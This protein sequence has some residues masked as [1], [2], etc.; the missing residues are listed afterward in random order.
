MGTRAS[1]ETPR[2]AQIL[3]ASSTE[4]LSDSCD[5]SRSTSHPNWI[6]RSIAGT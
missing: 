6:A 4:A 3:E 2:W 1:E 5:V